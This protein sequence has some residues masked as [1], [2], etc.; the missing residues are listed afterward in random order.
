[1][2]H[3]VW[4]ALSPLHTQTPTNIHPSIY[5]KHTEIE[6]AVA[7]LKGILPG[8]AKIVARH[9]TLPVLGCVKVSLDPASQVIS[10][11]ANNLDE[12][13]TVRLQNKAA[14]VPGELLLPL[15]MLSQLIKGCANA[16]SV[17]LIS[18]KSETRIRYT[19]AGNTVD[20][21]VDHIP[22]EEFP[23]AQGIEGEFITLDE[24]FKG[25]LKEAFDCASGDSTRYVL[26]GA[27]LDVRDKAAHYV[28]GTDGRHLYCANSFHFSLPEPLI[29]STR[30]FL[31]WPGFVADGP[32][33][34]RMLPAIHVDPNDKKADKSQERPPWLQIDSEHW[35]YIARAIDGQYPNWKQVLPSD[36]DRWTRLTLQPEAVQMMQQAVPLLPGD[37]LTN[38]TI[39]LRVT[40]DQVLL[41]AQGRDDQNETRMA[42]PEVR[43]DG[44]PIEVALN[45]TYLLQALRFGLHEMR[46]EDSLAPMVFC[47]PAKRMV[48]MPIRIE[49]QAPV[50]AQPA[51]QEATP[52]TTTHFSS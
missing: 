20:R 35:S 4:L 19:V 51:G 29:V 21:V 41:C 22:V 37:D 1:M 36:T 28:V 42:V 47:S 5:M 50:P 33:K 43:V 30:K 39:V 31:S 38:Q 34:L 25:A 52:S 18:N 17:R 8:L 32:W 6:I 12:I 11:E 27:C 10:L 13:A 7:E 44:K 3:N 15:N 23:A 16:Q 24:T 9:T 45:R 48:V 2:R 40:A 26:N 46:I 14:G 49:A